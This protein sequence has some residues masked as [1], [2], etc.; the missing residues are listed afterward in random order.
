M[1]VRTG[2]ALADGCRAGLRFFREPEA[3]RP[4]ALTCCNDLVARGLLKALAEF[5]IRV[6]QYEMGRKA[7]ELLL[8]RTGAHR[9]AA[10]RR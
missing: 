6:P 2:D 8:R 7:A 1:I 10:S 5:G 4:T 9:D 3:L